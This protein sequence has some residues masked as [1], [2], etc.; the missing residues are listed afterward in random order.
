MNKT[1][2]LMTDPELYA[3]CKKC[4]AEALEARRKFIGLLP[5]VNVR[6]L[7]ERRGYSSIYHFAAVLGGVGRRLVDDVL[8]LEKR[9]EAMPKLHA[10]LV[11]G[12]IGLSKLSR[13][14]SI[15]NVENEAEI[16]E[17]IMTLSRR[18]VEVMV[19]EA[20]S[21][22]RKMK[23][24]GICDLN[25]SGH[26]V[27]LSGDCIVGHDFAETQ[28]MDGLVMTL[29]GC[30]FTPGCKS[31]DVISPAGQNHD[32]EI[33][34]A[35]SPEVKIKLKELID[36][37]IDIN[38]IILGAMCAREAEIARQKMEIVQ[39]Q[40]AKRK[41]KSG[42]AI[43]SSKPTAESRHIPVKIR[44]ILKLE[45]GSKC[46]HQGCGQR[47]EQIHHEKP[48]AFFAE[49]D[50]RSMKPLCRAHHELEHAT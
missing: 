24:G 41:E 20:Q 11:N 3:I 23:N 50:P 30:D 1:Q 43:V 25:V 2:A 26:L 42:T 32:Y 6:R 46:A 33:L 39:A 13:V 12:E 9:F 16:C 8:R 19:I 48:F 17:K 47:A 35:L 15:V 29:S 18:A 4:G 40:K 36:K 49:H 37:E 34:N 10:A 5:E 14:A 31:E 28:N 44:R 7:Y 21:V 27:D 38:E 45:F 22:E